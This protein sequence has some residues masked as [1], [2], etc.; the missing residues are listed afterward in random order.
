[1]PGPADDLGYDPTA[2]QLVARLHT[3]SD[4][5][6]LV[7]APADVPPPDP[8]RARG[9]TT[10]PAR[11]PGV[12]WWTLFAGYT[13]EPALYGIQARPARQDSGFPAGSQ[14]PFTSGT[15]RAVIRPVPGA[16]DAGYRGGA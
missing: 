12:T 15:T 16:W 5:T 1:M 14:D 11:M 2:A 13:E 10:R 9:V 4:P 3:H 6:A 7:N 8:F